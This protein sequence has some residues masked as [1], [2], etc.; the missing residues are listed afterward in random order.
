MQGESKMGQ[1]L[2][3]IGFDKFLGVAIIVL[4]FYFGIKMYL[5]SLRDDDS[6][7]LGKRARDEDGRFIADDPSTKANEAYYGGEKLRKSL[8]TKKKVD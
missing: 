2:I 6:T 4:G 5:I 8:K 3:D 1:W 7:V